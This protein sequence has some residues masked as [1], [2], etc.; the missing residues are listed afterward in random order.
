VDPVGFVRSLILPSLALGMGMAAFIAR[1]LRSS[2]LDVLGQDY[3]RTARAR[4]LSES[5]IVRRHA[6]RPASIPAITVVG[7]EIG[8]LIGGAIVIE[9]VFAYPGMGTLIIRS[10]GARD[11]PVVQAAILLFAIG[12]V[13]VNLLT[14]L[15]YAIIDPRVRRR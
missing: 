8:Y 5:A 1:V 4:G 6:L 15:M 12:F 3:I 14:D 2:L 9:R 10:I 11:Y 7:L 13:G